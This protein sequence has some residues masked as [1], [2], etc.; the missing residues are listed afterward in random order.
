MGTELV[1]SGETQIC[2]RAQPSTEFHL[3]TRKLWTAPGIGEQVHTFPM[4]VT[5]TFL[6]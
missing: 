1:Y 3:G 6:I 4:V 2:E 5:L